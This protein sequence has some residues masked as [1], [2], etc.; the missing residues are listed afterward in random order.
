MAIVVNPITTSNASGSFNVQSGGYVQGIIQDDPVNIYKIAGGVLKSTQ[1]LPVYAG[2]AI[3]EFIP[4]GDDPMGSSVDIASN[5]NVLNITGFSVFNSLHSAIISQSSNVPTISG[6]MG[7]QFCRLG[8]GVRVPLAIDSALAS[9]D[10]SLITSQVSWDFTNQQ[11][12]PY[13]SQTTQLTISALTWLGGV[14]AATTSAS[15][16]LVTGDWVTING[17]VP[18]GYNGDF[19]IT[20]VDS[21][22]FTYSLPINPGTSPATGTPVVLAGG[23]ALPVKIL[24]IQVGNSR[25]AVYNSVTGSVN[26]NNSGACA[27]VL[28]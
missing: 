10:G 27:L 4:I 12:V 28:L 3:S 18:S 14:A 20:V 15:N 6:G 26:Y 8:S 16:T 1:T 13:N 24:K 17:A 11:L 21:T 25:V 19:K 5:S 23:G 7:I 9:L 2:M 22:H